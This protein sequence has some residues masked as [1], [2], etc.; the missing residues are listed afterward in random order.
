MGD[1]IDG[2]SWPN[3]AGGETRPSIV[4]G[5]EDAEELQTYLHEKQQGFVDQLEM[6]VQ[7]EAKTIPPGN[8]EQL[9]SPQEEGISLNVP[10]LA[11]FNTSNSAKV[12]KEKKAE[13]V[14]Q[15]KP[16][17]RL[18]GSSSVALELPGPENYPPK[19]APASKLWTTE[20]SSATKLRMEDF[21]LGAN[22][23]LTVGQ[24]L[25]LAVRNYGQRDALAYKVEDHWEKITFKQFYNRCKSAAKSFLK[26]GLERFCGVCILG[27]NSP[28]WFIADVGAILAG[29]LAVGIYATNSADACKYVIDNCK[30][31]IVVVENNNQLQK[32]MEIRKRLSHLKAIVQ[33]KDALETEHS[34]IFTWKQFL[35]L[36]HSIS[37]AELAELINGQKSNHCCTLIYTS[38]TTGTPKGAMLSH[39]NITWTAHTAGATVGISPLTPE[40]IVSFLPLSHIAAQMMDLWIPM[41][42]G[43]TVYFAQPDALKSTLVE[44]LKDVHPTAFM[45]VPRVW[46][47][48]EETLKQMAANSSP[49]KRKLAAWAKVKGLRASYNIMNG[50]DSTPWGYALANKLVFRKVRNALGLDHCTRCFTG[51]APISKA[52]LDFFLSLR[53]T[54]CELY[55][56]SESSG[57]HTISY[58]ESFRV[59]SCGKDMEGCK[60][61]L[62]NSDRDGVGEICFWGRN[63]FMGYLNMDE[64]TI[65]TIDE[66]GWLHSGDL[67]KFDS[68]RY[69]YITG[70]IKEMII[71]D[72]GENIAP[73]PIEDAVMTKLPLISNAMLIGDKRKFL[74]IL[75]T[76][77]C[78]MDNETGEPLDDLAPPTIDFCRKNGCSVTHLSDFVKRQDPMIEKAIQ[79]AIDTVNKDATSN[80]QRIQKWIILDKDFTVSGGELGPTMKLRRPFVAEMYKEEIDSLYN[81]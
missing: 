51:A 45:G 79:D 31:N 33:Y 70:R 78:N 1:V 64:Q 20:K 74:S 34:G 81:E 41:T 47:K 76:L 36:G 54:I 24:M 27:F 58:P 62:S 68:G 30:A 39:D 48:I 25:Q 61:K 3:D 21:G 5:N 65:S 67:G 22:T 17:P 71:T 29:G 23:P 43:S 53:I 72:G 42:F 69:L 28:E 59:T 44:T 60:S 19:V 66:D 2:N 10:S 77:K 38:G 80:A 16:T 8:S 40:R 73:I 55:G 52:T 13:H 14:P 63:V 57:P 26:L 12:A 75:L 46:E 56:M 7:L 49:L 50:I 35:K 18:S 15:M 11:D 37:D 9:V 4:Q 32:I 6:H